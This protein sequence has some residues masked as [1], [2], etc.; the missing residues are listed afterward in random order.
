[1]TDHVRLI[2]DLGRPL[3]EPAWPAGV[4]RV[5][6][7]ASLAPA[8][9]GLMRL[10][11]ADGG[12]SVPAAFDTWWAATRHD[13]EFDASLCF[14][15]AAAGE[16]VGFVLCWTSSFVKDVVVNPGWRRHGI[17]T[18][19]LSSALGDLRRRGHRAATLKMHA[20]NTAAR[21]LYDRF[22]FRDG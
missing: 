12:G 4:A 11:Y 10:A 21:R 13:R 7:G 3:P 14:V 15:A 8:V 5:P 1:M 20:D 18:A 19:L 6:F 17:G 16:P 22:G 9:H 2:C